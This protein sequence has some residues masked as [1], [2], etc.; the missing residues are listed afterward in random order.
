M[1][2]ARKSPPLLLPTSAAK[3][4]GSLSNY[5]LYVRG[6]TKPLKGETQAERGKSTFSTLQTSVDFVRHFWL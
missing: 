5:A 6:K 2:C 4:V 1:G 3:L